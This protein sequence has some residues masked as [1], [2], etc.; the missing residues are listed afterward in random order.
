MTREVA[1][2]DDRYAVRR[3]RLITPMRVVLFLALVA[4]AALGGYALLMDKGRTQIPI[5]A[6]GLSVGGLSLLG[7]AFVGGA[8]AQGARR[9]GSAVRAFVAAVFGGLC[10]LGAAGSLGAAV[11]LLQLWGSTG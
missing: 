9:D 1:V 8:A 4:A 5:L 3:G 6:A 11:V 10:A 2:D 7:F